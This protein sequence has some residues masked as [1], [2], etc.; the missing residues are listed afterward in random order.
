LT[1]TDA[2]SWTP[3]IGA[4]GVK[5]LVLSHLVPPDDPQHTEQM[6]IDAAKLHFQGPVVVGKDLLEI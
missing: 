5:V 1:W 3:P 4:A 2:P 6:W